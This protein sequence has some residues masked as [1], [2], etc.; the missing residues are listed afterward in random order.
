LKSTLLDGSYHTVDSDS[1]AFEICAKVGFKEAAKKGRNV[2][3]EPIMKLEVNVPDEYVG[4]ITSDLN[5]TRA[6]LKVSSI[7]T[8]TR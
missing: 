1:L 7:K 3:L 2:L 6:M 4:D 8:V 5:K